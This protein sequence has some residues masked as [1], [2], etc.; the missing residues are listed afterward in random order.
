MIAGRCRGIARLGLAG[1]VL[2]SLAAGLPACSRKA[3]EPR[4]T[5]AVV[6]FTRPWLE[7]IYLE[8][9]PAPEEVGATVRLAATPGEY[10]PASLG[11]RAGVP[12]LG[13][14]WTA[15]DL[16]G[17]GGATIPRAALEFRATRYIDPGTVDSFRRWERP[18]GH[19]LLPAYLDPKATADIPAG[20]AQQYWLTLHVPETARPGVY[21]G[22][23]TFSAAGE[24]PATLPLELEV[25]PFRLEESGP[26]YFLAGDNWPVS[27]EVFRDDR[28][29]GMNTLCVNQGHAKVL[30]HYAGGRW[31]FPGLVENVAKVVEAAQKEGLGRYHAIGV[32]L[33]QHLVRSEIAALREAGIAVPA[34]ED[35]FDDRTD[36]WIFHGK[37]AAVDAPERF[38]GDYFPTPDPYARPTTEAGRL[39]YEGWVEAMKTLDAAAKERGWPKLWYWLTDEPHVNRGR[40][41]SALV[42]ARAARE[43][44]ADAL[45]TCNEPTVSEP[46]PEQQWMKPVGGEPALLFGD[47]L[48]V[49]CYHNAYLSPVTLE[50][51]RAA[52]AQFGTYV[53]VYANQPAAV[54]FLSGYFA[55]RLQ[56]DV[57][58]LWQWGP[59][60]TDPEKGPRGF[61]RDWEAVREGIDDLRYV[62]AL[63]AALRSGK[64]SPAAR[65]AAQ[66]ALER[67]RA[68]VPSSMRET[69]F[70][71]SFTGTYIRGKTTFGSER[72]DA[73]RTTVAAALKG[74]AS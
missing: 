3:A 62:E 18:K 20:R 57:V 42:M 24:D 70:V 5:K 41:R 44:G 6:L 34:A 68:E 59:L 36:Y 10:E 46:D 74:L 71:D 14:D 67:V 9:R 35:G 61:L 15:S 43:A 22:T 17:P 60:G 37:G 50:R 21:R 69:S 54:R 25:Y 56:L 26:A 31:S 8:D 51:T 7:P 65:A 58:M 30:A 72:F 66:Q 13:A 63:E 12:L 1:L 28:A 73:L 38:K 32:M 27:E 64:G 49:R 19:P 16:A 39:V 53:N 4:D 11:V 23:L 52:K 45:V 48:K 55:H 29:H 47:L 2:A 33:Y 40:M